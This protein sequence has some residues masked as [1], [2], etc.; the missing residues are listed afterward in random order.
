MME[1]AG[2]AAAIERLGAGCDQIRR[3]TRKES[4]EHRRAGAEQDMDV[5]VLR[6]ALAVSG[7]LGRGVAF[8]DGDTGEVPRKRTAASSPAMLPPSTTACPG[9]GGVGA[10]LAAIR[11]IVQRPSWRCV[12]EARVWQQ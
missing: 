10:P 12:R 8:D 1:P 6:H 4:L 5:L 11:T 2:I 3:E 7:R 9:R